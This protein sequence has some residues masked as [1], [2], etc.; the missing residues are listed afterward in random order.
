MI[1]LQYSTNY[2][3]RQQKQRDESRNPPISNQAQQTSNKTFPLSEHVAARK[4]KITF[5][6]EYFGNS[7]TVW[8]LPKSNLGPASPPGL[9]WGR[10]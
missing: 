2:D 10:E 3:N 5:L 9:G 8:S 1:E 7:N 6:D 4:M